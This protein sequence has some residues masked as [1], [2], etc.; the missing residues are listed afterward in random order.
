[1][2][3][4]VIFGRPQTGKTGRLIEEMNACRYSAL[5]FSLENPQSHLRE[6]G[7]QDSVPV[8]ED[9]NLK[10]LG[11]QSWTRV[12]VVGYVSLSKTG[13]VANGQVQY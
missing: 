10:L 8:L 7:L 3:M 9:L 2:Q 13:A 12:K 5:I 4:H 6:R 11:S 1:M